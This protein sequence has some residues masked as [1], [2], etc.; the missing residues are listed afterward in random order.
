MTYNA[1][2]QTRSVTSGGTTTDLSYL[3][4]GQK[5]LVADGS[6]SLHND[7]L[8]LASYT[9]GSGTSYFTR[10]LSG[11]QIDERT[12]SG[13]YNY[14]FD[15]NGSIV[16]L[17]DSS[18]HLVNQY[19][20]DPYGNTTSSSGSAPDYFGFQG[21]YQA[22]ASLTHY[23]DRY[24]NPADAR[25]TQQDPMQHINSLTQND[26]YSCAGDDPINSAEP[27]GE[28]SLQQGCAILGS[29]LSL[30]GGLNSPYQSMESP[31]V[32]EAGQL[33]T[34]AGD[35]LSELGD[36]ETSL[37]DELGSAGDVIAG[38]VGGG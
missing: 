15:C 13:S 10:A 37:E 6:A 19:S 30:C 5:E 11:Q 20:Y 3:G 8:G 29:I 9:S 33:A 16:G 2:G 12:P 26:R 32:R 17:T 35:A 23:G 4:D 27:S 14:L 22:P 18:D 38:F 21:G 1:L 31:V 25:W 36:E 7:V 34:E 28:G 24:Q